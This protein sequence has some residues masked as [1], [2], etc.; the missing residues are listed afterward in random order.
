MPTDCIPFTAIPHTSQLFRDY[1]YDFQRVQRFYSLNP[2]QR[3]WFP[4]VAASL[5]YDDERRQR[6]ANVLERQNRAFG[7]SEQTLAGIQRL[8]AGAAAAVTGQQVALFGGPMFS[9]LKA[10]SAVR[11]AEEARAAGVDCVP[12]FWLATEDHDLA[13]VNHVTLLTSK[14]KLERLA[15]QS[16][17]AANAP[18]SEIRFGSEIESVVARA[19]ELLGESEVTELIKRAY[20]PGET[21]GSAFAQLFARLFADFGVVLLDASDPELHEIGRPVYRAAAMGAEEIDLALLQRGKELRAAG[22][23]EQVKVTPSS[24]LLFQQRNGAREVV[25]RRNGGFVIG[26]DLVSREELLAQIAAE[27]QRF[28]A[29]VLL[30]PVVQDFLLP[31]IAYSGGPAEVA[32]FAQAAV[33]YEEVLGRVTPVLPRFSATVVDTRAQRLMTK[34]RVTLTDL[35]HGPEVFRELL[36]LRTMPGELD[37]RFVDAEEAVVGAMA[38]ISAS[39]QK[40]D[41]TLVEAAGRAAS[42]MLYQLRRLRKRAG[43]AQLHKNEELNRHAEWL[44]SVL[45]PAKNLQEREISG[46]SFLA[47]HGRELLQTLSEAAKADC[48]DHQVV[49]L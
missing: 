19:S 20:R 7:A 3:D 1:L 33:V 45:F 9:L 13:E 12:V 40:M 23:H 26:R 27:P 49:Y 47:R 42:K 18:I 29:N 46:V 44:S 32:Y 22:Y 4:K 25:H 30:R 35:F 8:R 5:P 39:L 43:N 31:T 34:Y 41:P 15:T 21:L 14:G 36:A 37:A 38:G 24:T 48:P 28:S 17:G 11:V 6:V 10:V 2:R 16:K